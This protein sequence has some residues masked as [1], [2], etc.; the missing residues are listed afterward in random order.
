MAAPKGTRPPGGSRKGKPNK[1]TVAAREAFQMAF[2]ES[3]GPVELAIWAKENR[4]EFYKLFARL[5]PVAISNPDGSTWSPVLNVTIDAAKPD[6][7]S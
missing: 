5:I 6:A 3:G 1:T 2:D 4:T 7:S